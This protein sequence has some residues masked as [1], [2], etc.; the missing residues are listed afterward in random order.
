MS[1]SLLPLV[2]LLLL[3]L[4]APAFPARALE[5]GYTS[6]T[7]SCSRP[8]AHAAMMPA[9]ATTPRALPEPLAMQGR[10]CRV[11]APQ[12]GELGLPAIWVEPDTL[13]FGNYDGSPLSPD[14]LSRDWAPG[15]R[16][17][18]LAAR[19]LPRTATHPRRRPNRRRARRGDDVASHWSRQP[20]GNAA[21]LRASLQSQDGCSRCRCCRGSPENSERTVIVR[22]GAN[23][24]PTPGLSRAKRCAKCLRCLDG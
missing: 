8:R 15:L 21:S 7:F 9:P 24:V 6:P 4:G 23:P 20:R 16:F 10:P 19:R 17:F 5:G 2:S 18:G 11:F 12:R 13:V 3:L 22:R 1:P 14:K